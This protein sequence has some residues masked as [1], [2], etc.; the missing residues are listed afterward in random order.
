M[1]SIRMNVHQNKSEYRMIEQAMPTREEISSLHTSFVFAWHFLFLM[2][3]HADNFCLPNDRY[4]LYRCSNTCFL[5]TFE[6]IK[7]KYSLT[8]N[9]F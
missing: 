5:S 4:P 2:A 6:K 8:L 7:N 1:A 3:A 9:I